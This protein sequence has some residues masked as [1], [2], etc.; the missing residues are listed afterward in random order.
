MGKKME[1]VKVNSYQKANFIV[2]EMKK[3][4]RIAFYEKFYS[5]DD[6]FHLI[7][8]YVLFYNVLV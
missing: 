3:Q 1:S 6:N 2:Q 5:M 4:N 8:Y 7:V